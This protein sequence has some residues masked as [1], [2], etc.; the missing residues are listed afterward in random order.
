MESREP[1]TVTSPSLVTD[2]LKISEPKTAT[3]SPTEPPLLTQ[4]VTFFAKP[5]SR[6]LAD[7]PDE[8]S[9]AIAA[10]PLH[11]SSDILL[12]TLREDTKPFK[13]PDELVSPAI[14]VKIL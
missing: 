7:T 13:K 12:P 5:K 10:L 8:F 2:A 6:L 4:S 3:K 14:A 1:R 9:S 11:E